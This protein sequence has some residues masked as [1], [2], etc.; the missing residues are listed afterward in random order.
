MRH[1]ITDIVPYFNYLKLGLQTTVYK[2][3]FVSHL[4]KVNN[5]NIR[6]VRELA[7]IKSTQ[8]LSI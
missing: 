2:L 5:G 4:F 7:Y 3:A 8:G 1:M 6:T